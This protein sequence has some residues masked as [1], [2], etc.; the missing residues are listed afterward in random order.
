MPAVVLRIRFTSGDQTDV[1]YHPAEPIQE[2]EVVDHITNILSS[3][4]GVLLCQHGDRLLV[5]FGRGVASVELSPRGA[6]L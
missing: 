4:T 3:D 6:V 5:L 1:T 2:H